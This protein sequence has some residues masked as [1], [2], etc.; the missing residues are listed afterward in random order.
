MVRSPK[1]EGSG[2]LA[3]RAPVVWD[4]VANSACLKLSSASEWL[5]EDRYCTREIAVGSPF[6][7]G[8]AGTRGGDYCA[9]EDKR[10]RDWT[11]IAEKTRR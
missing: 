5:G 8:D 4:C 3:Y 6:E 7:N 1:G 10:A 9:P 11:G 2:R